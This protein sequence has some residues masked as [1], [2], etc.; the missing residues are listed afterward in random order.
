M[1]GEHWS[2]FGLIGRVVAC[3]REARKLG[4]RGREV[5]SAIW[6]DFQVSFTGTDDADD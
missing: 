5:K 3:I 2:R 6:E 1:K 4:K